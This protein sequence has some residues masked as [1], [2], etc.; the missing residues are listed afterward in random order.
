MKKFLKSGEILATRELM[1]AR[2]GGAAFLAEDGGEGFISGRIAGGEAIEASWSERVSGSRR[3]RRGSDVFNVMVVVRIR[4][5][6]PRRVLFI[7]RSLQRIALSTG[8]DP[9]AYT[10]DPITV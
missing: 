7:R 10:L 5:A 1:A 2:L 3:Q 4:C 6:T 9:V 8:G